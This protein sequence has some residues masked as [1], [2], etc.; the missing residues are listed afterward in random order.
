LNIRGESRLRSAASFQ[1]HQTPQGVF[2][3]A[4]TALHLKAYTLRQGEKTMPNR[5]AAQPPQTETRTEENPNRL[6]WKVPTLADLLQRLSVSSAN[7]SLK[8]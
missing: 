2:A 8:R 1:C 5:S 6:E 3:L 4:Q 7:P